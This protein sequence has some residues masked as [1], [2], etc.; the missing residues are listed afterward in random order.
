V[1]FLD[2]FEGMDDGE[3]ECALEAKALQKE[4]L[5]LGLVRIFLPKQCSDCEHWAETEEDPLVGFCGCR[6]SLW[7]NKPTRNISD[8]DHWRAA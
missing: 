4:G 1:E 8:C 5:K 3:N 7:H 2:E 6:K